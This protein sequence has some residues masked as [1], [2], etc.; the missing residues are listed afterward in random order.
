[1]FHLID[2]SNGYPKV[3]TMTNSK[4][5]N[6]LLKDDSNIFEETGVKI[7][8][9]HL[10]KWGIIVGICKDLQISQQISLNHSACKDKWLQLTSSEAL[11]SVEDLCIHCFI[12]T[13][14][15]WNPGITDNDF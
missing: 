11:H 3:E 8:N 10:Y 6:K 4:M 13:Y 14:A 1:M 7:K 15:P 2:G 9:H 5:G 12:G